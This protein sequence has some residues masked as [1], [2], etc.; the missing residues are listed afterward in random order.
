MDG[1]QRVVLRRGRQEGHAR[2]GAARGPRRAL[3]PTTSPY[4]RSRSRASNPCSRIVGGKVVHAAEDFDRLAPAPLPASPSWAPAHARACRDRTSQRLRTES[5]ATP[6]PTLISGV[7]T[8]GCVALGRTV[9]WL[10]AGWPG[11]CPHWHTP[12]RSRY[13][14]VRHDED[15]GYLAD[16]PADRLARSDQAHRVSPGRPGWY[17]SL[18]GELRER[19]EYCSRTPMGSLNGGRRFPP[20]EVHALRRPSSRAS[21]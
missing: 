17:L 18:G 12:R 5:A 10:R 4:P 14:T 13:R 20:A 16:P 6:A 3:R 9:A 1:G 11:P 2:A 19:F 8:C 21:A 7:L 15:Y